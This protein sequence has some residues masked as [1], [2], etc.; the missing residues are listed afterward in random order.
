MFF[1]QAQVIQ[2]R[3]DQYRGRLL[4]L[5]KAALDTGRAAYGE[6]Y[7]IRVGTGTIKPAPKATKAAQIINQVGI[8]SYPCL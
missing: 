2:S 4:T 8:L 7:N 5:E 6:A 1:F 3:V